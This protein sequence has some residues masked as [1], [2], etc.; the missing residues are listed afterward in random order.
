MKMMSSRDQII[1]L[2]ENFEKNNKISVAVINE[3]RNS[4]DHVIRPITPGKDLNKEFADAK[5]HLF[6]A[7]TMLMRY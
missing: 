3:L 4:F 2:A 5:D 1:I 7:G 6:R